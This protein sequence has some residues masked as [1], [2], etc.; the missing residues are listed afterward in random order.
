MNITT[1]TIYHSILL[2]AADEWGVDYEDVERDIGQQF[3]PIVRFMS[4]AVA[5][6]LEKVYY[7]LNDTERRLQERLAKVLLPE[8]HHL[9]QPAHALATATPASDPEIIDESATFLKE[10]E[11]FENGVAFSPLF[12]MRLQPLKLHVMATESSLID[13]GRR[14]STRR[15]RLTNEKEETKRILL[16]FEAK[17]F[18]ANWEGACLWFDLRGKSP[19]ESERARFFEALPNS[20]CMFGNNETIPV[21]GLPKK[22]FMLEDYLNGNERL[23]TYVRARYDRHF[24]TFTESEIPELEPLPAKEFLSK[25]FSRFLEDEEAVKKQLSQLPRDITMPLFWMEIRLSR[26]IEV[27]QLSSRLNIKFNVFPVVNRRLNGHKSGEHHYLRTNAIKWLHLQPKEDFLAIRKVY[28]EKPD[29]P[30]FTFKPFADFKEDKNPSY[31]IRHGGVGRWD[32]FNAWKRLAYIVGILQENYAHHELIQKAADSLSLEE[33]HTLLGKKISEKAYS[34]NPTRD[35]YVLLHS[36]IAS[37]VRVRVEY[38]TS[39][40]SAV[41]GIGAKSVLKCTSKLASSLDSDSI[42]LI[43][44]VTDGRDSLTETQQLDAMK[45]SLLS[46]GRIVTRED[47]KVFC[48]EF[49]GDKLSMVN[50]RD[51]VGI[52]PRLEFGMTRLLEVLI[53]PTTAAI[54]EDWEGLCHQ[55]EVLLMEKSASTIPVRVKLSEEHSMK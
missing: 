22:H 14:L 4:G 7:H 26:P 35:I 1:E 50:V 34:E 38:W 42:E 11:D 25:W 28:A 48:K 36:G 20:Y 23:Q 41:N 37:G 19:D 9:P 32:D 53:T 45:S 44:T 54:K 16:G 21:S 10:D 24:L 30:V 15:G 17:E 18:I 13:S 33:L 2:R 47:V 31:T 49:L 5:S 12:P 39:Q 6:E 29:S 43:T 40:G 55:L 27:V 8:Y 52:D 46:R 51:G 3:D